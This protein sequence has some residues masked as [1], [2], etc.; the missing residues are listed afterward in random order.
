MSKAAY[1]IKEIA[2]MGIGSQSHIRRMIKSGQ[3]PA[4]KLGS[5]DLVPSW[6]VEENFGKNDAA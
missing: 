3:I 1:S 5:R 4:V 2:E 6:W